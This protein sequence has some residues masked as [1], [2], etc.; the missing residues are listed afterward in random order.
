MYSLFIVIGY[1][2]GAMFVC[3]PVYIFRLYPA[4]QSLMIYI[5]FS[6][7]GLTKVVLPLAFELS[8]SIT[9]KYNWVMFGIAII[10]FFDCICLLLVRTP[11][12]DRLRTVR[13]DVSNHTKP[14]YKIGSG[15]DDDTQKT[16]KSPLEPSSGPDYAYTYG[17][18][19]DDHTME[20][21]TPSKHDHSHRNTLGS[22]DTV[23]EHDIIID[24]QTELED[25]SNQVCFVLRNNRTLVVY[26]YIIVTLLSMDM[27]LHSAIQSGLSVFI[28]T[29]CH[30]FLHV[31]ISNGRYMISCYFLGQ[32]LYR[33]IF[34]VF[35][36]DKY[37]RHMHPKKTISLG[38]ALITVCSVIFLF[39]LDDLMVLY[40][41]YSLSGAFGGMIFPDIYKWCEYMKPVSG[42]LS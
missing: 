6:I 16:D 25:I 21:T 26:E 19:S 20:N 1:S 42:V 34:A 29:Y 2:L 41:V 32:L 22:H 17:N 4:S 36:G 38:F 14:K 40:V 5:L 28:T 12:H 11:Q 10:T 35:I 39:W 3:F 8:L 15:K 31:D 7:Y 18:V 13:A 24:S 30:L 27:F 9:T 37:R 23:D 33:L